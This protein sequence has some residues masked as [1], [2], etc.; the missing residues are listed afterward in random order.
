MPNR[1]TIY[2]VSILILA[3]SQIVLAEP[4]P[5]IQYLMDEPVSMLDWGIY[6]MDKWLK[7]RSFVGSIEPKP[8]LQTTYDWDD[9]KIVIRVKPALLM[10]GFGSEKDAQKWCEDVV[11]NVRLF[12]DI[13]L[14]T[15]KRFNP[16]VPNPLYQFFIHVGY[17]HSTK[18]KDLAKELDKLVEIRLW[19]SS[20]KRSMQCMAPL[21]GKDVFCSEPQNIL[22]EIL[23][24]DPLRKKK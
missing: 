6:Q 18:P 13:N 5:T 17:K 10:H 9:N 15:G 4:T 7:T 24:F 20:K 14:Q 3:T 2:V 1:F 11:E 16:P 22:D 21:L 12:F 19:V 8:D 23:E